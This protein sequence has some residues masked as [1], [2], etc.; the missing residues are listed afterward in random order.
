[1]LERIA[2]PRRDIR[3][4]VA[5]DDGQLGAATA[6]FDAG[7]STAAG[8]SALI[9]AAALDAGLEFTELMAQIIAN[10]SQA[11][12]PHPKQPRSNRV[13][14]PARKWQNEYGHGL[15]RLGLHVE[16]IAA[17]DLEP[18]GA[19]ARALKKTIVTYR[20]ESKKH[21]LSLARVDEEADALKQAL[22]PRARPAAQI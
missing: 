6:A 16:V 4:F 21:K 8:L 15:G 1:M 14:R 18:R 13:G 20:A 19:R 11:D 12:A 7:V 5:D 3:A 2:T 17:V 22:R 9:E 10:H